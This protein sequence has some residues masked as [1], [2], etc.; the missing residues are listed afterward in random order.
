[1]SL[2][3]DVEATVE[4]TIAVEYPMYLQVN[5]LDMDPT[6]ANAQAQRMIDDT[7][8]KLIEQGI[9]YE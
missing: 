7:K 6:V 5:G 9:V 1:M 4:K 8:A 2:E 3:D